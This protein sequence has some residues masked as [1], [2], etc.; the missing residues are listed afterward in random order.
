VLPPGLVNV[1]SGV[2]TVVGD[3]IVRHRGVPRIGFTGSVQTG[4]AIQRA[5]AEVAVKHISLELGGK[6]PF[7]AFPDTDP[8]RIANAAVSGM[9]FAWSGQSCGSTSRLMLH[10]SIYD[11][12]VD[13]IAEQVRA[14][15]QGDPLD[16]KSEMG[17]VNSE[18]HFKRIM[19]I[20]ESA[21]Q[22][23]ATLVTGGSRPP[24][25]QFQRGYWVEP[26]V[27]GDVTMNM[28]VA[29]EEVFGPVLAIFKWK[30]TDEVIAMANGL[31]LGLT[32][33]VWTNDLNVAMQSARKLESGLVWI[34]GSGRHY[35]GTG[36]NGWKNSGL[37][38]EEC[39][40]EVLSYTRTKA[41]HIIL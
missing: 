9:N 10:E 1:V 4:M 34:N 32:A 8:E 22:Q 5:A 18:P 7:I 29:R 15:K 37:G 24:G 14:I 13:L 38:R 36:F 27:F 31:E 28:R 3:A 17:P 33:A 26:T 39:L 16:P 6:N 35:L 25:E 40:D 23:G 19:D 21:K 11:E 12:V 2:G 30:T 41:V 20:I